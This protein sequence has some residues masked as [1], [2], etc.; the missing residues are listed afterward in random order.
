MWTKVGIRYKTVSPFPVFLFTITFSYRNHSIKCLYWI[1]Y[2]KE[3]RTAVDVLLGLLMKKS[4]SILLELVAIIQAKI[5][6]EFLFR[7][8]WYSTHTLLWDLLWPAIW[9]YCWGAYFK[10]TVIYAHFRTFVT[11]LISW[12]HLKMMSLVQPKTTN[13]GDPP[14]PG[15]HAH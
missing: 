13:F 7:G 11:P 4:P 15:L 5:D 8:H 9:S 6:W 14:S 3:H 2:V 10:C 1:F 12:Y